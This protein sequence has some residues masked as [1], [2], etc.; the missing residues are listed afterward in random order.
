MERRE[1]FLTAEWTNIVMLNYAV[2]PGLLERYVPSGTQLDAFEGKTYVSLIGF[3]FQRTKLRSIT[4]PF[5]QSF[6]EVN[7]RFYV[8]YAGKR[9]AVFIRELVPKRAVAWIARFAFNENYSFAPMSH[10]LEY[11]LTGDVARAEYRWRIGGKSFAMHIETEEQSYIPAAGSLSQ[12][13][14]EHY[15]G[16]AAQRVG[17]CLEYAVEHPPWRVRD[18]KRVTFTGDTS[19]LYGTELSRVLAQEPA[20]AFFA[21]GSAVSVSRGRRIRQFPGT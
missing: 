11:R 5:H 21:E 17:L 16:Y 1:I 18:A 12:F 20:S 15:W 2:D 13:I 3:E 10:Q 4:V 9:G 7:L 8:Q 19:E 6:E 14:T